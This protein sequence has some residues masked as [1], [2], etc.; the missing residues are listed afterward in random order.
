MRDTGRLT[1]LR[2]TLANAGLEP[3]EKHARVPLGCAS[4][5][6]ALNGGLARGALHEIFVS[7]GHETAGAG[8]AVALAQRLNAR[9]H[10]LWI[11]QDFSALEHGE[12][13]A[14]GLLELGL[15]PSRVLVLQVSDAVSA[16]RAAGDALTCAAL[17][18]VL[19]ETTGEAKIL[20]LVT[21]RRLTLASAQDGVTAFLLRFNAKP[22]AS[23]AETRWHIRSQRSPI[24]NEHWG[25]PV[26]ETELV[27]NR[28]GTTGH[29][30]VEWSCD[31][32]L[33][34]ELGSEET[35][36]RSAVVPASSDRP[37]SAAMGA[38]R[39]ANSASGLRA[40]V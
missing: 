7:P 16:L 39:R 21:S 15:D 25:N 35:A 6:L 36:D 40:I 13:S 37:A 11:R 34:R 9:K 12:L 5:D 29:W 24:T 32:A 26:F 28:H 17:G 2:A 19:I 31:D 30:M 4:L 33:F 18:A 20:N 22:Q 3:P 14:A 8:F 1:R 23:A 10:L 38:E 27:R